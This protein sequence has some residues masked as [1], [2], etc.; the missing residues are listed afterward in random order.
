[1]AASFLPLPPQS[2]LFLLCVSLVKILITGPETHLDNWVQS[3]Y[4]KILKLIIF[5]KTRF[6]NKV[7]FM[8][9]R[10]RMWTNL[11]HGEKA[12]FNIL[13]LLSEYS[14][15]WLHSTWLSLFFI[16]LGWSWFYISSFSFSDPRTQW[17][18]FKSTTW[19]P[20][21]QVSQKLPKYR[22][23]MSYRESKKLL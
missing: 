1:M 5:S 18:D 3:P 17:R 11:F 4:L 10:I 2:Y 9:L 23:V 19:N 21:F 15:A 13:Q 14:W 6:P 7:T 20:A 12:P 16:I 8:V 22:L